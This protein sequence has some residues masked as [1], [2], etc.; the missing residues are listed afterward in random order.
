VFLTLKHGIR[1]LCAGTGGSVVTLAS[2]HAL[3]GV[4]GIAGYSAAK[5][6]VV[7]LTRAVASYYARYDVRANSLAPGLVYTGSPYHQEMLED[8]LRGPAL[9]DLYLG[10]IGQPS[11]VSNATVFL[12]SDEA[13]FITG[14]VLPIDGG[15]VSAAHMRRPSV[16]DLPQYTRKRER[17][18][19]Y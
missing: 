7:S 6:G 18:P 12:L 14:V 3:R 15:A 4:N 11:D 10:R 1:A 9:W 19:Q 5:G 17:A 16:P 2:Q 8:P 13:A